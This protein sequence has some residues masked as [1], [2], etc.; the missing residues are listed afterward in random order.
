MSTSINRFPVYWTQCVCQAWLYI[1]QRFDPLRT[2]RKHP[3][4]QTVGSGVR[5]LEQE[6]EAHRWLQWM[7]TWMIHYRLSPDN[8]FPLFICPHTP[9]PPAW[10]TALHLST[11]SFFPLP[12]PFISVV[13]PTAQPLHWQRAGSNPS[14]GPRNSACWILQLWSFWSF[15]LRET[16]KIA[17]RQAGADRQTEMEN[18]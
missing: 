18:V 10:L 4:T 15:P 11:F 17:D 2:P 1:I 7:R 6:A 9:L 5:G 8:F 14:H 16:G 12:P 13:L 3:H